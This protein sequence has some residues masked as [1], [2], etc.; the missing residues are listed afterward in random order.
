[1]SKMAK[2][3]ASGMKKPMMKKGGSMKGL[4]KMF[5]SLSPEQKQA[6][7]AKKGTEVNKPVSKPLVEMMKGGKSPDMSLPMEARMG[8]AMDYMKRGGRVATNRATKNMRKK[9]GMMKGKKKGS[10]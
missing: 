9:K 5:A 1:M 4:K 7:M 3:M 2:M 8:M 10:K 6:V